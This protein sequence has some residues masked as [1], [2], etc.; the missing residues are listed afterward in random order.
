MKIR[1]PKYKNVIFL[2]S[3]LFAVVLLF[4]I[5]PGYYNFVSSFADVTIQK[6]S[7]DDS[8]A[9]SNKLVDLKEEQYKLKKHFFGEFTTS[10]NNYSFSNALEKFNVNNSEF[11]ISIN[12]IK[13]LK[14]IKKGRLNFQRINLGMTS[15]FENIYNYCRWL[16]VAGST[17]DFEE[18]AIL[19]QKDSQLL[20]TNLQLDVLH[21]GVEQ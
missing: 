7:G 20:Q 12:S 8:E 19:K 10:E 17:I 13:P 6:L 11:D 1:I 16:E 5:I 9:L 4:E 3:A 18:V 14:K 21:S 2:T 15:D